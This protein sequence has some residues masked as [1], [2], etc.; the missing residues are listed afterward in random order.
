LFYTGRLE[1][2]TAD[3]VGPI[4]YGLCKLIIMQTV[5]VVSDF[6]A[7]CLIISEQRIVRT[8]SSKLDIQMS[9]AMV[10]MSEARPNE[11]VLCFCRHDYCNAASTTTGR[12][13][14][15]IYACAAALLLILYRR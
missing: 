13:T 11:G 4:G 14:S 2:K 9:Y 10:C 5:I 6:L 12:Q 3:N 8:C 7:F 1:P 15:A